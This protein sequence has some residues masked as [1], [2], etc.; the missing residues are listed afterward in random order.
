MSRRLLLAC[1]M[2]GILILGSGIISAGGPDECCS[3]KHPFDYCCEC[4]PNTS[5]DGMLPLGPPTTLFCGDNNDYE[6]NFSTAREQF[7]ATVV[8][9]DPCSCYTGVTYDVGWAQE[10]VDIKHCILFTEECDGFPPSVPSPQRRYRLTS[11]GL[12]SCSQVWDFYDPAFAQSGPPPMSN[13]HPCPWYPSSTNF[14]N[15]K[16]NNPYQ[17]S[18]EDNPSAAFGHGTTPPGPDVVVLSAS[19]D[20]S[21]DTQVLL[22]C[23]TGQWYSALNVTV[24]WR[25]TFTIIDECRWN[26]MYL[27]G[28]NNSGF[29]GNFDS[30]YDI[31]DDTWHEAPDLLWCCERDV[32][33]GT[34]LSEHIN[35]SITFGAGT[36]P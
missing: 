8:P 27:H 21:T 15:V 12:G 22:Q 19:L 24:H 11:C 28:V 31:T 7:F 18:F 34:S 13:P 29:E 14:G 5:F 35:N 4:F 9:D 10:L 17:V 3:D 36:C 25:A 2:L 6:L 26:T 33:C 30:F 23:D 16:C 32:V 1:L 20:M